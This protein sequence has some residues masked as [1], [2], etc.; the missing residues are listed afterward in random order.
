MQ[1]GHPYGRVVK[2][3]RWSGRVL[4]VYDLTGEV[5]Q[6]RGACPA[7]AEEINDIIGIIVI[8]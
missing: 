3:E 7:A 4:A 1:V 5:L 8:N 2:V 6:L